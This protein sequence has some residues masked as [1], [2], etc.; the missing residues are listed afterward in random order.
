MAD[1]HPV[2]DEIKAP[3]VKVVDENG[4]MLGEMITSEALRIARQRGLD[5]IVVAADARPPV[6]KILD[7]DK[8]RYEKR[9]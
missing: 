5:L 7:C 8:Y 6:C 2:N 1:E 4:T 9:R 3:R